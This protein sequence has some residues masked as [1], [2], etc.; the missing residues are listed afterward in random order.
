MYGVHGRAGRGAG[1]YRFAVVALLSATS[2]C[3]A[4]GAEAM[5]QVKHMTASCAGPLAQVAVLPH[6]RTLRPR[7]AAI[8]DPADPL[9]LQE[10]AA[11]AMLAADPVTSG[12]YYVDDH[13]VPYADAKPVARGWNNK[14]GQAEPGPRGHS[15]HRA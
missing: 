12:V 4:L 5:E 15:R 11:R 13:F 2:M 9:A 10:M 8:A 6:V 3:F 7:L 1:S 14:R